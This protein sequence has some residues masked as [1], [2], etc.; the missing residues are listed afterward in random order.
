MD[1]QN[2]QE[3]VE[4]TTEQT[5]DLEAMSQRLDNILNG[6]EQMN[7]ELDS[8]KAI[9][10]KQNKVIE[11]QMAEIGELKKVNLELANHDPSQKVMTVEEMLGAA[12]VH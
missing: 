9:I 7:T 4:E 5:L 6:T 10:E 1:E 3:T 8:M 12:F 2:K 11:K